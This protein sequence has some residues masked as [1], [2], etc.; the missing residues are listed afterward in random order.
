MRGCLTWV[1]VGIAA[2]LVA[3][4]LFAPTVAGG[5]ATAS[6]HAAGFSSND[7]HVTVTAEPPIEL[8]TLH[9][10][11]IH[12][13]ASGATFAGLHM[14]GLDLLLSDVGLIG[15]TAGSVE[16]TLT[17][18]QLPTELG[19][20]ATISS[21]A[22][23]GPS[24]D[25]R[26]ILTLSAA[27]VRTLASAAVEAQIGAKATKVAL[28]APDKVTVSVSGITVRGRLTVDEAG[29]LTLVPTSPAGF[30][31]PIAILRPG[32]GQPLRFTSVAVRTNGATITGTVDPSLFRS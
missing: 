7:E 26:V 18:L 4:W 27:D 17:G 22:V 9:A 2:V 13:Q 14:T 5:L 29:G 24:S 3:T 28:A 16:G 32:P 15:R 31:G 20:T 25:L 10:D 23:T 30:S 1:F 11:R 12:L 21:V 8:L 19:P 6:L